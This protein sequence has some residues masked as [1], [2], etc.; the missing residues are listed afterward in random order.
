MADEFLETYVRRCEASE[1]VR[2]ADE[3]RRTCEPHQ[4]GEALER[5]RA[6][7]DCEDGAVRIHHRWAERLR[8]PAGERA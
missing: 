1:E 8:A 3:H 7:L 5:Y 4:R 2:S 6:A